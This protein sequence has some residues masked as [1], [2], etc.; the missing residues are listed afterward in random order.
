MTPAMMAPKLAAVRP[1]ALY[2]VAE[3]E[4]EAAP[5]GPPVTP[6]APLGAGAAPVGAAPLGMAELRRPLG[7]GT[8]VA[9]F[10]GG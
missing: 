9:V 5:E 3:G 1:A 10:L 7:L 8:R 2:G 6:A 4:A